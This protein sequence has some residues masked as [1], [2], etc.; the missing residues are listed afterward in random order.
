VHDIELKQPL[1]GEIGGLLGG[2]GQEH[3]LASPR[4]TIVALK[5]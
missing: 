5:S 2:F 3:A 4:L 1:P